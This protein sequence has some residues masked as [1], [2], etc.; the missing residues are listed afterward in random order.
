M[1]R[2]PP[3]GGAGEG[4]KSTKGWPA[5]GGRPEMEETAVLFTA[6]VKHGM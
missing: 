6:D 3:R 5:I 2:R 4:R 1:G